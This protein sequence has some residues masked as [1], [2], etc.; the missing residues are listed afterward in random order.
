MSISL[1][2]ALFGFQCSQLSSFLLRFTQCSKP[3]DDWMLPT[4][5]E[6]C[7]DEDLIVG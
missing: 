4:Y 2:A 3:E 6:F 7:L 1:G 5:L